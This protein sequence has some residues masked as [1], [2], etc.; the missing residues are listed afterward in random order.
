MSRTGKSGRRAVDECCP[1][2]RGDGR[3]RDH[4][5]RQRASFWGE[6]NLLKWAPGMDVELWEQTESDRVLLFTWVNCRERELHLNTALQSYKI[7][8][9]EIFKRH[10]LGGAALSLQP[11]KH[12]PGSPI[13]LLG[14]A[15]CPW[16][17]PG[18]WRYSETGPNLSSCGHRGVGV[19]GPG[20]LILGPRAPQPL[21]PRVPETFG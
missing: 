4:S 9:H 20:T 8:I 16:G 10:S 17:A 6:E 14:E 11:A 2:P 12:P 18:L 19:S 5:R 21:Q 3:I 15:L 7:K 13:C 1:G